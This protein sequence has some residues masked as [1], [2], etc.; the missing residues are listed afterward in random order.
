MR[1]IC[2]TGNFIQTTTSCANPCPGQTYPDTTT[3]TCESCNGKCAVC[4]GPAPTQCTSCTTTN[5][6]FG[7]ECYATT[8]PDNTYYGNTISNTCTKCPAPCLTCSHPGTTTT[9]S[10]CI[11]GYYL[12]TTTC[13]P[14]IAHCKTCNTAST[15]CDVCYTN[16][17][18]DVAIVSNDKTCICD[19]GYFMHIGTC[20]ATCP[21]GF[22]A[23]TSTRK[24]ESCTPN[25]ASCNSLT[26]CTSCASG[27]TLSN[28]NWCI[29][30]SGYFL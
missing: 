20:L 15:E 22:W 9:C 6:L 7:T 11:D 8:C 29:C 4:F 19:V 1:C 2:E 10:A 28:T 12:S 23:S 17:V 30:S 13:L 3:N 26:F 18:A 27:Y 14:C 16:Y 5:F 21:A 24:C 25:C